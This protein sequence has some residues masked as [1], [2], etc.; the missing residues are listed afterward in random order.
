MIVTLTMV[1]GTRWKFPRSTGQD[2]DSVR[3][4]DFKLGWVLVYC[5]NGNFFAVPSNNIAHIEAV[6]DMSAAVEVRQ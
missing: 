4:P 2:G 3:I 6:S 1:D 5:A